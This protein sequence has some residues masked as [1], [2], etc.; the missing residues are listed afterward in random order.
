MRPVWLAARK[1]GQVWVRTRVRSRGSFSEG[2]RPP[3]VRRSGVEDVQKGDDVR[4]S[5][6]PSNGSLIKVEVVSEQMQ[7]Q[8][9]T[10]H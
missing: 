8:S 7:K 6:D 9:G 5:Y 1:T 4:A 3:H 2:D 10:K